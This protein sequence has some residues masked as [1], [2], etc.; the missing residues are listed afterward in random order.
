M[1]DELK[2]FAA[3]A[4][5]QEYGG[6]G[7]MVTGS[8]IYG[9]GDPMAALQPGNM[10]TEDALKRL[11]VIALWDAVAKIN[12]ALAQ[13]KKVNDAMRADEV[14]EQSLK[15]HDAYIKGIVQGKIE[16]QNLILAADPDQADKM[17]V[18]AEGAL[19]Q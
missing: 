8:I 16:V 4:A 6:P 18:G 5:G 19:N 15:E 17:K 14:D 7:D 9:D 13:A 12:L 3:G 2:Q 10:I 1:S 11:R